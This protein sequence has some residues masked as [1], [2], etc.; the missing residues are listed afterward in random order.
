M[1]YIFYIN[2]SPIAVAAAH[3]QQAVLRKLLS[4]PLNPNTKEVLSLEEILAE[5]ANQLTADRRT[6]SRLQVNVDFFTLPTVL[7][8]RFLLFIAQKCNRR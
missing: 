5:G 8:H 2:F 3:G 4:H 6:G 1:N 7:I